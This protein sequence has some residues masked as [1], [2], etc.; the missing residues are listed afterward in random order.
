MA[1][2]RTYEIRNPEAPASYNQRAGVGKDLVDAMYGEDLTKAR[3]S[4]MIDTL[5]HGK[6]ADKKALFTE[7]AAR[8]EAVS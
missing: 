3:A 4:E 7:F 5:R 6:K 8:L 1:Q 2:A